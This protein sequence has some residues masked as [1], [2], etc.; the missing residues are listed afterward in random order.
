M[1]IENKRTGKAIKRVQAIQAGP[2]RFRSA[3]VWGARVLP[4]TAQSF[5]LPRLEKQGVTGGYLCLC[6]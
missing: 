4:F 1:I 3:G 2:R 5:R 6:D